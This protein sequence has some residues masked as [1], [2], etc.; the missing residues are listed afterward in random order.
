MR[1]CTVPVAAACALV[2]SVGLAAAQERGGEHQGGK[3]PAQHGPAA[4]P[5]HGPGPAQAHAPG[6]ERRQ[7]PA[8]RES[9]APA[10]RVERSSPQIHGRGE[11]G[12]AQALPKRRRAEQ[13]SE[14]IHQQLERGRAA[15]QSRARAERRDVEQRRE[16]DRKRTEERGRT[17]QEQQRLQRERRAAEQPGQRPEREIAGA[18]RER[19]AQRHE[20]FQRERERLDDR[21]RQRLQESFDLRRA[22]LGDARFDWSVGHRIPSGVRLYPVPAAVI[23]VFPYYRDYDYFVVGDTVCVVDPRTYIVVDVIDE[24]YRLGPRHQVARLSLSSSE[25]AF[26]RDSIPADF[27]EARI[28]IRLALGAEIP[29]S[30]ELYEFPIVALD[31]VPELRDYRFVVAEDEIAIV[32]PV[33]RSIALVIDRS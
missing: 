25:I 24:T 2:A 26:V 23:S 1:R 29:S 5:T 21:Q 20:E 33:D 11:S 4:G 7:A 14:R 3:G 10:Q 32:D 16:A 6:P 12:D 31:R 15:E 19:V 28:R 9:H 22:R 27:P 30:V 18:D 13:Q 8:A 17:A